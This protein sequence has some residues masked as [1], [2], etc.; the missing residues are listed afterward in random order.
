MIESWYAN[1]PGLVVL[2]PSTPQQAYDMIVE[3]SALPDPVLI[4]EHIGLYG[5]RGG[6]PA[7]GCR[8]TSTSRPMRSTPRS[9]PANGT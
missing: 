5:L 7:G 3:A 4:L 1:D 2:A 9:P 8:S 6:K